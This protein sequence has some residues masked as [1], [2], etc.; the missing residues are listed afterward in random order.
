ME[1]IKNMQCG[2]I[3]TNIM[4]QGIN[5]TTGDYSRGVAGFW[6]ENGNIQ[7]PVNEIAIAGNLKDMFCNIDAIGHDIETRNHVHCG[8]VLISSMKIAG[9]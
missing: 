7:Y 2:L 8:S 3:V 5:I 9:L 4:G 1:L 6:V